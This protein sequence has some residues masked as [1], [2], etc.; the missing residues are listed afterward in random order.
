MKMIPATRRWRW[1]EDF[2]VTSPRPADYAV[3]V[4][5]FLLLG[6]L[7]VWERNHAIVLNRQ[8]FRLQEQ[9]SALRNETDRLASQATELGDRQRIVQRAES[10]GMVFPQKGELSWIYWVPHP[11][12]SKRSTHGRVAGFVSP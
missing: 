11:T 10:L 4:V 5:A 9:I 3:A 12:R 6:L 7:F 8:V 2:D 1:L